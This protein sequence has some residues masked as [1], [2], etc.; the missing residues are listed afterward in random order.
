M[1]DKKKGNFFTVPNNV[2]DIGLTPPQLAI[3]LYLT[4]CGNNANGAFP[5][6]RTI[7]KK[8][9]IS[10]PTVT[11][12]IDELE[13]MGLLKKQKRWG[14]K[15]NESNVYTVIE[16]H[17]V[18]TP[19]KESLPPLVNDI[20]HGGKAALPYKE[21]PYKELNYKEKIYI[22][23]VQIDG[24]V[25]IKLYNASYKK[26]FGKDHPL[27]TEEQ[28]ESIMSMVEHLEGFGVTADEFEEKVKE[29]FTFLPERNDGKIF[30]FLHASARHFEG[31]SHD[32]F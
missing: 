12:T 11:K 31:P 7:Q 5:S 1:S 9:S 30:A 25:F 27:V 10:R 13:N 16:P 28:H 2:F 17:I 32:Y 19:G 20:N 22:D 4:R 8:C 23:F 24:H 29:H 21:L 18:P 6:L 26:K 15:G 3:Y 14:E